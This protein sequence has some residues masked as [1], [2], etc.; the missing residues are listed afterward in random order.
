MSET[1]SRHYVEFNIPGLRVVN[2]LNDHSHWRTRLR[3]SRAQHVV[4]EAI[5]KHALHGYSWLYR[6]LTVTM[7]RI[8]PRTFDSDG[9]VASMKFVRDSIAMVLG[10]DDGDPSIT[11]VALYERGASGE[12]AVRIRIERADE[13]REAVS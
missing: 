9:T 1:V 3:R 8:A 13:A 11:W 2:E 7:T 4:V 10:V 5:A 6:P 12:Y